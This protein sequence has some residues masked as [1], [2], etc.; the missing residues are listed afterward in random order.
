MW[1][2]FKFDLKNI[3]LTCNKIMTR[4]YVAIVNLLTNEETRFTKNIN[5]WPEVVGVFRRLQFLIRINVN[6]QEIKLY[7][8][9]L[10]KQ[11]ELITSS[12]NLP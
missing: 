6:P 11:W 7:K 1:D 10:H 3:Y 8:Y 5:S 9:G 12:D 4:Y 2:F